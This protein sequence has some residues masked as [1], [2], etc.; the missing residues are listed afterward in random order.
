MKVAIET[1]GCKVNFYESEVIKGIFLE[2]NY[3]IVTLDEAPDVVVINT[4]SVTNQSDAKDRKIIRKAKRENPNSIIIVC[5]CYTQQDPKELDSLDIDIILGNKDKT[6]II[7]LLEEYL[8]NKTQIKKIY[9]LDNI[10]FEE[11]QIA[12]SYDRT[13]AF[14][15]IE[16][17]CDNYCSYCIIPY[18][19]GNVRFKDYDSAYNEIKGLVE[20]GFKEIVLTGIHTGRYPNLTKLIHEISK[21]DGLE[22]IR[23]SSIEITEINNEEFLNELKNNPKLCKHM[24]IPVQSAENNTLKMMNRKYTIEEFTDIINKIRNIKPEINITT[25]LIVGFP[26]ETEEEFN[27][28]IRNAEK[29]KFGKIHVFPYSKRN[30]TA[31]SKMK[32][33]VSDKQKD[34][35]TH[36]MLALSDKLEKEYYQKYI[37]KEISILA[38]EFKDGYTYGYSDNY[39]RIKINHNIPKGTIVKVKITSLENLTLIGD[40][41]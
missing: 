25:D 1:L 10:E 23:I 27:K 31:A 5:G 18:V 32:N 30:G 37:G 29:L 14:V 4:C 40:L 19:R 35:R 21:L 16:D 17:G 13:R 39:L 22:R 24:H 36:L 12:K 6:Q 9:N 20:D 26:T 11:M 41:L 15:K 38:E 3:Q 28:C 34:E 8:K 33:I 2:N 7:T